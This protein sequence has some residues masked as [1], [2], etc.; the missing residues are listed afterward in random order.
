MQLTNLFYPLCFLP[1]E[2]YIEPASHT[3]PTGNNY[4]FTCNAESQNSPAPT[5]VWKNSA[6]QEIGNDPGQFVVVFTQEDTT[7]VSTLT[8]LNAEEVDAGVY[9]CVHKEGGL[10]KFDG[11]LDVFDEKG[12]GLI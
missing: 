10:G 2:L 6:Q 3:G 7:T 1:T 12:N 4:T 5:I 11:T 9:S 8:I